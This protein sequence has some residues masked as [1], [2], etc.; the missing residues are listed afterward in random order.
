M[1]EGKQLTLESEV[2]IGAASRPSHC[3][4]RFSPRQVGD[5]HDVGGHH[6]YTARHARHTKYKQASSSNTS[7]Q[8]E[9][10]LKN[11][12]WTRTFPP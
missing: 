12:Q 4:Q 11:Y 8:H 1:V 9:E 3:I 6:S 7:L 10:I 5:G 2:W